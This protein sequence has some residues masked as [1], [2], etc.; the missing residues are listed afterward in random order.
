ML[1]GTMVSQ[2]ARGIPPSATVSDRPGPKGPL[3]DTLLN[4]VVD[5]PGDGSQEMLAA[6][7]QL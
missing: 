1:P 2:R 3:A 7:D 4:L 6:K 5:V